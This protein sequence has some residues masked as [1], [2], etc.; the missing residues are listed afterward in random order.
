M[1]QKRR[2]IDIKGRLK[3]ENGSEKSYKIRR[4][5]NGREKSYKS[6]RRPFSF[7]FFLLFKT[8]EICFGSTKMGIL[9]QEKA[10]DAEKKMREK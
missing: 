6:R 7:S 8:T 2:K 9:Y 10:F 1:E 5:K 4:G 3:I